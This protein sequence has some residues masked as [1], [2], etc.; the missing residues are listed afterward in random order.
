M[1]VNLSQ[2]LQTALINRINEQEWI[3]MTTEMVAIG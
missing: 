1:M 2:P 3:N